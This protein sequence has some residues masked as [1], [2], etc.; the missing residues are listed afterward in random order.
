MSL[1]RQEKFAAFLRGEYVPGRVEAANACPEPDLDL[2][3][4]QDLDHV[5]H[6]DSPVHDGFTFPHLED[7]DPDGLDRFIR[8]TYRA[9]LTTD[10]DFLQ[11]RRWRCLPATLTNAIKRMGEDWV[12][13]Q[14]RFVA[15]E[16][17]PRKIR[18]PGKY[19]S[20]IL[21]KNPY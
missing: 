18:H 17:K 12:R 15:A 20:H 9:L 3:K 21:A 5:D 16:I 10:P 4:I 19:L 13:Q 1:N 8:G 11:A 2:S 14:I 7:L 6:V